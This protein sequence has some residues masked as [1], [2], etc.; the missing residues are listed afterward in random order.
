MEKQ[1]LINHLKTY[2]PFNSTINI[3][4]TRNRLIRVR[5]NIFTTNINIH[6]I[7]LKADKNIIHDIIN[8]ILQRNTQKIKESKKN[9]SK[10][11]ND[12]YTSKTT[13]INNNYEY[14]NIL[15]MFDEIILNLK[16]IYKN[17][18]FNKLKITW[19]KNYKK[20]RVSIRFGSFDK[21]N[22]LIRIHPCLDK[23]TIPDYFIRSIIY[24]EISHFIIQAINKDSMPHS[25]EFK[26]VL[27]Q[28]DPEYKISRKWEKENKR[29]FFV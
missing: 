14:K 29:M 24:H 13:R 20:H 15:S 7:F 11:F 17:I 25:K 6:P 26:N 1:E 19:G 2:L 5:K 22:I 27:K 16:Q 28:I 9:L 21:K 8:F 23:K 18:D 3:K 10:F 4:N 12:N